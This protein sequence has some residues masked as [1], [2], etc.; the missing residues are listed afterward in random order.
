M[1][2]KEK[3]Q[4]LFSKHRRVNGWNRGFVNI[5]CVFGGGKILGRI[6]VNGKKFKKPFYLMEIDKSMFDS[7]SIPHTKK[8]AFEILEAKFKE[9]YE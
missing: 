7:F 5:F 2:K 9:E 8:L 1:E 4:I 3:V 6:K